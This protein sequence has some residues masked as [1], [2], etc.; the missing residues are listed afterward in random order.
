MSSSSLAEKGE[1]SVEENEEASEQDNTEEAGRQLRRRLDVVFRPDAPVDS[2]SLPLGAVYWL[3]SQPHNNVLLHGCIHLRITSDP[4]P[5]G[6]KQ[7]MTT[8]PQPRRPLRSLFPQLHSIWLDHVDAGLLNLEGIRVLR[9]DGAAAVRSLTKSHKVL[10][11]RS[12]A[13]TVLAPP[14][15]LASLPQLRDP[16][17]EES[18]MRLLESESKSYDPFIASLTHLQWSLHPDT[19]WWN[20]AMTL[21]HKKP[22][23]WQDWTNACNCGTWTYPTID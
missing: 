11:H 18:P 2:I 10:L 4:W 23:W 13:D 6:T 16:L 21:T 8:E 19:S 22:S 17:Q 12:D 15:I 1:R 14:L 7:S 20:M 9:I 5:A 3:L